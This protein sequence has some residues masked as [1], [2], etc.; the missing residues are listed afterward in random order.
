M[1]G[2]SVK[3]KGTADIWTHPGYK[4]A[5]V[6]GRGFTLNPGVRHLGV[7]YPSVKQAKLALEEGSR[8]RREERNLKEFLKTF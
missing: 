2:W 5:I 3:R 7:Q 1:S 4:G 6:D 8:L